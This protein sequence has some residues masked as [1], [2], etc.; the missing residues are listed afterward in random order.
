MRLYMIS[1]RADPRATFSKAKE[2]ASLFSIRLVREFELQTP[3]MGEAWFY[4]KVQNTEEEMV[5]KI[6]VR[7]DPRLVELLVATN[8]LA[9][10]AGLLA[11]VSKNVGR[12]CQEHNVCTLVPCTDMKWKNYISN[13]E[14]LLDRYAQEPAPSENPDQPAGQ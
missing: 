11:E 5:L 12:L 2:A 6:T 10:Q 8:N 7:E 9:S 13:C 14:S 4:G 1:Q 3:Y